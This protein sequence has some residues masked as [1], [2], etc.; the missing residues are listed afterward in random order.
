MCK[1]QHRAEVI[2]E[3]LDILESLDSEEVL[4][5]GEGILEICEKRRGASVAGFHLS[6]VILN[7]HTVDET[8]KEIGHGHQIELKGVARLRKGADSNIK[9]VS[10]SLARLIVLT[11]TPICLRSRKISFDLLMVEDQ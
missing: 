8:S 4:N 5:I 2:N 1:E 3:R 6:K 11:G 9:D 7:N 10:S